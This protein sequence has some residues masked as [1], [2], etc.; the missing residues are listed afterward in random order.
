MNKT[1]SFH[2]LGCKLNFAESSTIVKKFTDNG[3]KKVKFG[4]KAELSIINTCTVTSQADKKSRQAIKKAIKSSESTKVIVIGCSAQLFKKEL[5]EIEGVSFV[6]GTKD[7]FK[8][9]EIYK[10]F[11]EINIKNPDT[12]DNI[13]SYDSAFSMGDRTR[14]FLKIQDGCNYVCTYCTIPLARGLSR[15][16]YIKNIVNQ[17]NEIAE[18]GFQEIVLT[19]V[20]IGDFGKTTN[21]TFFDLLKQLNKV[22]KIKRY[23][24]SS[25]EPNLLTS[26]IIN[27]VKNSQ[28]FLP[29]FHIPLQAGSDK[30]LALMKRRY[31]STFFKNKIKEVN[32]IIPDAFL[33]IDVI[34][35]FPNET[36]KDFMETYNLLE[37]LP[38]SYLHIF[39]YSDR[40]NT[41][42][43][44][45]KNKINGNIISQ[46]ANSLKKLSNKKHSIFYKNNL[47]KHYEV[48]FEAQKVN[49]KMYGYTT[50]YI[51]I[52]IKYNENFVNKIKRIKLQKINENGNVE[53]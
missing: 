16:T 15:N 50:N 31:N 3:F 51:K 39:P 17:A 26:E 5:S 46:R 44:L 10:N 41:A 53:I 25:I 12:T 18:K 1:I 37:E 19:G 28:K 38:I 42:S 8:I 30:I 22:E 52:E 49:N 29:H 7:K 14:S 11:D 20:N 27:F 2:T 9:Y 48:L 21:E 6:A 13:Q 24:I 23:R 47:N 40:K 36:E 45:M 32:K 43:N 35:G 34:V 4:E 33:G